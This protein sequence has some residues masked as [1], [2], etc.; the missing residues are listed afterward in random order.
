MLLSSNRAHIAQELF[1]AFDEFLRAG[2]DVP[3]L[4]FGKICNIGVVGVHPRLE[5]ILVDFRK[6]W[7]DQTWLDQELMKRRLDAR[8]FL[9]LYFLREESRTG[10][11][12]DRIVRATDGLPIP[13]LLKDGARPSEVV[14]RFLKA[15]AN[16]NLGVLVHR[17]T[18]SAVKS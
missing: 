1:D 10:E 15:D 9:A 7:F 16:N 8:M 17:S 5:S 4:V 12:E 3:R 13:F 14:L 18:P 6:L 11:R 2:K